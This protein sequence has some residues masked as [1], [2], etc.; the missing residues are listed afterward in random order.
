MTKKVADKIAEGLKE[1][2]SVVKGETKL[3]IVC[4]RCEV[5]LARPV[6]LPVRA[7]PDKCP[8]CGKPTSLRIMTAAGVA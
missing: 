6:R 1:A 5:T 4:P 8:T 2:I 7:D 3:E